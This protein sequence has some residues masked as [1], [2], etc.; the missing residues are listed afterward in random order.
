[1]SFLNKN[2]ETSPLEQISNFRDESGVSTR[3]LEIGL[4]FI[5]QRKHFV[6]TVIVILSLTSLITLSYSIYHFSHF[7]IVGIEQ[8]R[9]LRNEIGSNSNLVI[10]P[11]FSG[12]YLSASDVTLLLNQS[13]QSDIVAKVSNSHT[14]SVLNFSYYFN[15]AGEQVGTGR[16]FIFP[17][18]TKYVMALSQKISSLQSGAEIVIQDINYSPVSREIL[19][20]WEEYRADRLNFLVEDAAFTSGQDSG[21]SEKISLGE[22]HFKITNQGGFSYKQLPLDIVLRNGDRIVSVSRYYIENFR[23]G[24]TK[25]PRISWPGSWSGISQIEIIP[26]VNIL[27]ESVYLKY[28]SE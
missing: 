1:M 18:D 3:R 21:L 23:S 25:T 22:L 5:R 13:N 24:E 19:P 17:G 10:R 12:S 26:D 28:S 16:T 2:K 6:V 4:W 20:V 11:N 27:D 7:L 14:R 15:V 9:Q 8:D